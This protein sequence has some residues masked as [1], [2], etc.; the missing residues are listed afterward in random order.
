MAQT[1]QLSLTVALT[2][3]PPAISSA[4]V[5]P[6]L[7]YHTCHATDHIPHPLPQVCMSNSK[8]STPVIPHLSQV[9]MSNSKCSSCLNKYAPVYNST[10]LLPV[11][12]RSEVWEGGRS[13]TCVQ[14]HWTS[15]GLHQV[16]C[17][18]GSQEWRG[19]EDLFSS[20]SG[21]NFRL[22]F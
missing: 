3:M 5:A 21:D 22:P 8:C 19:D 7:S 11:C 4:F 16:R 10:G 1:L 2:L 14:Q 17:V 18:G 15:T 12:T 20:I 9:C 6:H 13:G